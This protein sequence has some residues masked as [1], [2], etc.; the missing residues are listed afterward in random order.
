MQIQLARID[1]RLIHGQVA[2]VWV[3]MLNVERILVVS[4][5]VTRNPM[6]KTMLMQAAPP[7]IKVNVITPERLVENFN[8]P[9]FMNVK[10][11]LLFTNPLE[12]VQVVKGGVILSS[13]NVGGMSYT[14]GKKMISNFVAVDE[15]DVEAFYYL[16][17][18]GIEIETRKV[19]A[20][21]KQDLMELIRKKKLF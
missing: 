10:V 16:S 15:K 2:T 19:I 14:S 13:V 8:H 7:G 17:D 3:K 12:V 11:M 6:R 1:D 21:N 9:L 20:D 4:H 18:K 5:E